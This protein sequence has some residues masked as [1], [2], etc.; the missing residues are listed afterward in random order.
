MLSL[1]N[2]IHNLYGDYAFDMKGLLIKVGRK[3]INFCKLGVLIINLLVFRLFELVCLQKNN[4]HCFKH[5]E[6]LFENN[7]LLKLN[8]F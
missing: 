4:L 1:C 7:Y 3:I 6:I 5:F 8:K 2:R